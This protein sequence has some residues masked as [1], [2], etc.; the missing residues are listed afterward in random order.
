[1]ASLRRHAFVAKP[2][3]IPEPINMKTDPKITYSEIDSPIGPLLLYG[4]SRGLSGV[5]MTKQRH[6]EGKQSHW[7]RD[8]PRWRDA[9]KQLREYFQGKRQ[10]FDVPLDLAGTDFQRKVWSALQ[11]I[12]YGRTA[13]YADIA[14][15]IRNP[16][17]MRAV[18][19]ANGR[20]PVAIIVPCH[21]VIGA[22]G[23]LTGYGGG[24]ERKRTLLDLE[25][26][27]TAMSLKKSRAR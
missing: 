13:S 5:E 18:G 17:A 27:T 26:G 2:F 21:R 19:L 16:K 9:A 8:D 12:P 22:D 24:L 4:T 1:M 11:K 3:L 6:F 15:R 25:N 23:S 7:K 20:N 14:R 10:D